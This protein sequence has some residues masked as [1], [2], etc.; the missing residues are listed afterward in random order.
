MARKS[1]RVTS[2][3][4]ARLA[5]V[6]R[7]TVSLVLNDVPHARIAP[8]TRRRV[9][10]AARQLGYRPNAAARSLVRQQAMTLGLILCH[11]PAHVY[12]DPFLPQVLLGIT[13]ALQK[14]EYR[15]LLETVAE[16]T[17][18]EDYLDLAREKRID[19][20]IISGPR[21]DDMALRRLHGEGVPIVLLGHLPDLDIPSVDVDNVRAAYTAV[22]HLIRLGH[23]RIGIITNGPLHYTAS[24]E[25]LAGYRQ[26]L[27]K[28]GLPYDPALVVEG[29][30]TAESGEE[31]M[32]HLLG[33]H[34]RPTAV[35][36]AS[37]T[38]ALGALVTLR[39]EGIHV[40]TEMAL[41]GFD[42]I[43]LAAYVDPP[44]TTVRLPAYELGREAARLL[45]ALVA[46]HTPPTTRTVLNTALVVRASCGALQSLRDPREKGG[47]TVSDVTGARS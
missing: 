27:A 11:P 8:E 43:P 35:F 14:T 26:A 1:R 6:S 45:L 5:G 13:G 28:H 19:G 12:T 9:L 4:V 16:P 25:R 20:F 24:Q 21:V 7:T 31:A 30:F 18:G 32:K 17:P 39:H 44:L 37:D 47:E 42:D 22:A 36:V 34:P 33:L 10:E 41:V 15:L 46:G 29:N 2:K 3:D 40:P 38:V 23:R